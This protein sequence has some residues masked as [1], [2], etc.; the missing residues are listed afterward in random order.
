MRTTLL[1]IKAKF[2]QTQ[3]IFQG[4]Y[5]VGLF[6][7]VATV[8]ATVAAA[9]AATSALVGGGNTACYNKQYYIEKAQNC[10]ETTAR[11]IISSR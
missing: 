10:R 5:T 8:S 3:T 11:T 6:I 4:E 1:D 7:V 9:V 2:T